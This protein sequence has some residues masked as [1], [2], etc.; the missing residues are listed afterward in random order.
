MILFKAL[1]INNYSS[2]N[3]E[4]LNRRCEKIQLFLNDRYGINIDFFKFGTIDDDF[5]KDNVT[6]AFYIKPNY[7]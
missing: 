7:Y 6:V 4:H 2:K 5:V 1:K 3:Q